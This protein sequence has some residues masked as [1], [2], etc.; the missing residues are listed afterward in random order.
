MYFAAQCA[1]TGLLHAVYPISNFIVACEVESKHLREV[2]FDR[3]E[4]IKD[5]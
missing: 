3:N 4:P 5:I 1:I 2:G